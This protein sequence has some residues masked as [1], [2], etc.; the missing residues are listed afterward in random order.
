MALD[1]LDAVTRLGRELDRPLDLRIGVHSG[2][3]VAGV[4]GTSKF[5][6][7][8]WGDTVNVA[9]QL[10][11]KGW[12]RGADERGHVAA[13]GRRRGGAARADRTERSRSPR[14]VRGASN[15]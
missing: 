12:G 1:M 5:I 15:W 6:Y 2:P 11:P 4:I 14:R 10:N 8:L 13:L 3:V 7:D 9:S